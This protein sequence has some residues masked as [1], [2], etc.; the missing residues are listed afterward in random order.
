MV[1]MNWPSGCTQNS[2]V[3]YY[4]FHML[5][6]QECIYIYIICTPD[7]THVIQKDRLLLRRLCFLCIGFSGHTTFNLLASNWDEAQPRL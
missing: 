4:G 5:L 2:A 1:Y 3:S 6:D 7:I